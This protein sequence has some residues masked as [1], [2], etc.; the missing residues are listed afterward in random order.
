MPKRKPTSPVEGRWQIVYMTE[1]DEDY[2]NEEVEAFIEFGAN[3]L[4]SFQFGYVQGE[5]DYHTT[6]RDGKLVVEFSWEGNDEMDPAMGRGWAVLRNGNLEGM[7]FFH[8][9]DESGFEARKKR[10]N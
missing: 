4:G 8:R 5:I 10:G 3:D 2:I 9:G 6:E 1:W 7:L